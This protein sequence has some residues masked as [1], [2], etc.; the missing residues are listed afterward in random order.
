MKAIVWFCAGLV[1]IV[2]VLFSAA[3]GIGYYL[4]SS[5]AKGTPRLGDGG[6]DLKSLS[7]RNQKLKARIEALAPKGVNIVVDTARNILWLKNGSETVRQAVVSCGTGKKL[8]D[9]AGKR[10]WVFDTPR[11]EHAVQVKK[12]APDWVKP[13][14]AFIEDGEPIP[15]KGSKDR[16]ES[17]VLGDYALGIG[18]GYYLHGT[19][20]KRLLGR[21][22]SHGC[23]R[24]GD[25][26]LEALYKNV[27]IGARVTIY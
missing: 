20:Y 22:V 5:A 18:N 6:G 27:P 19:L 17:G 3:E 12:V 4:S 10:E 26:D 25:E 14:W 15:P 2:A 24:I 1:L 9:P 8:V 11:G 16:V 23:I 7:D 21:N 13:D